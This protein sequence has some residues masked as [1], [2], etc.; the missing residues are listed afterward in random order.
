M[1]AIAPLVLADPTFATETVRL[2]AAPMVQVPALNETVRS[3]PVIA[4]E[5]SAALFARFTSEEF[6]S[7]ACG[8]AVEP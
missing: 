3:G 6:V 2:A 1:A 7:E 5:L 4:T 8:V